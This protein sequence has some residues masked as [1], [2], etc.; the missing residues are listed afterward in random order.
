M[1]LLDF[2]KNFIKARNLR[3]LDQK[4]AAVALGIG[5]SF[6]SKV[7]NNKK[8][9][10]IELIL[11]AAKFYDVKESFFFQAQDEI[12]INDLYTEKNKEFIQDLDLMTE[13]EIR[14]K[15]RIKLDGKEL[16]KE[17]LKGIIV[18]LR[19]MRSFDD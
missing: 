9:P 5:P 7:E 15:Y 1:C 14:D 12:N 17:E 13:D 3:G 10:S 18:Y 11:K 4:D 6:L 19:S 8:T 2:G 16:S